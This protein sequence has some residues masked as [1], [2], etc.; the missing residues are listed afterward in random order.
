MECGCMVRI[1]DEYYEQYAQ[2]MAFFCHKPF[3]PKS[4]GMLVRV[5]GGMAT[6]N[7]LPLGMYPMDDARIAIFL[8]FV[9]E[10]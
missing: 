3:F 10:V 8:D 9:E 7:W 4:I 2:D 5:Y 6:V 1:K